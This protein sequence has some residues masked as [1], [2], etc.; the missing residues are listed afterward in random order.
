MSKA[1]ILLIDDEPDLV[2]AMRYLLQDEGYQVSVALNG[3]EGIKAAHRSRPDLIILDVSMPNMD[4]LEVCARLRRDPGL[5]SVP[6]LFLS[7]YGT[8]QDR[9]KG[10]N[11]GGDDYVVK[12][13]NMDELVARVQALLRRSRLRPAPQ[14]TAEDDGVEINVGSL[15]LDPHTY[16]VHVDGRSELLTPVE[17]D[18]LRFLM[19]HAGQV[20]SSDELLQ[21]VWGYPP[22]TADP[23]LVRWHIKNL[24]SKIESDPLDP[25][26]LR[27]ITRHGY[28]V[29]ADPAHAA[30][31]AS[32]SG[33]GDAK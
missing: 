4:G 32:R 15:T 3:R 27:T 31:A 7:A 26:Y 25:V 33:S 9:T 14:E 17:F 16:R 21:E 30:Q 29:S 1:Q 10:L 28:M 11:Q 6:I 20:F 23:S 12:P 2:W 24:R 18:L 5:A 13:P 8:A 22:G 19:R